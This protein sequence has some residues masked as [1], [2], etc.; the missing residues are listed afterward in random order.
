MSR[1]VRIRRRQLQT[2]VRHFRRRSDGRRIT[3]V[4]TIHAGLPSYFLELKDL[5][6]DIE[7]A[8]AVVYCEGL[9]RFDGPP[10][11][12]PT[13]EEQEFLDR[14]ERQEQGDASWRERE[15]GF[16]AQRDLLTHHSWRNID[17]PARGMVRLVGLDGM[18]QWLDRQA[19][20]DDDPLTQLASRFNYLFFLRELAS[21]RPSVHRRVAAR[22]HPL[23]YTRRREIILERLRTAAADRDIVAA[24]GCGH[25]RAMCAD[26]RAHGFRQTSVSWHTAHPFPSLIEQAR[27]IKQLKLAQQNAAVRPTTDPVTASTTATSGDGDE[28][29]ANRTHP[30]PLPG[31]VERGHVR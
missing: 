31:E 2:A 18:R 29:T 21:W 24:Y 9:D 17:L 5:I 4:A 7:D 20:A 15:Q 19:T 11:P 28:D 26:L 13:P 27:L 23:L 14:W 1:G 30:S 6:C 10:E 8:G 16:A 3:L 12:E 25:H 22:E